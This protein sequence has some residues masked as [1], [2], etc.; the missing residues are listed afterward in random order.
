MNSEVSYTTTSA[1]DLS[2]FPTDLSN[3]ACHSLS[4]L[5]SPVFG[6]VRGTMNMYKGVVCSN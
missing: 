5:P 2:W 1:M 3:I 6:W 4:D